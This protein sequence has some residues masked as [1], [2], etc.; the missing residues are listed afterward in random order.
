MCAALKKKKKKKKEKEKGYTYYYFK[1]ERWKHLIYYLVRQK[2][3][4]YPA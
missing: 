4:S 1:E 3:D 2:Q